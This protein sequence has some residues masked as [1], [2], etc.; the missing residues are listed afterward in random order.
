MKD[1]I[2]TEIRTNRFNENYIIIPVSQLKQMHYICECNIEESNEIE[3]IKEYFIRKREIF[4][5]TLNNISKYKKTVNTIVVNKNN[6]LCKELFAN[7]RKLIDENMIENA[8]SIAIIE[9][10]TEMIDK[11]NKIKAEI[12]YFKKSKIRDN[13]QKL[14]ILVGVR[15]Y[16]S[17]I[18]NEFGEDIAN[19]I[20]EHD[21]L[22]DYQKIKNGA[23]PHEEDRHV[24]LYE[25]G[26]IKEV[27]LPEPT[28]YKRKIL[29]KIN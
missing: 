15:I 25:Q 17:N 9:Q 22:E 5:Y 8:L 20:W 23:L 4:K 21:S 3:E 10:N 2:E 11:I 12:T 7:T 1:N 6:A 24:F 14:N 28:K 26:I 29:T 16:H 19:Y 18:E 13:K 27:D